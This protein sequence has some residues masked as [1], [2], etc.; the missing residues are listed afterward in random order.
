M[1]KVLA[2]TAIALIAVIAFAGTSSLFY[3]GPYAES[4]LQRMLRHRSGADQGY[5]IFSEKR[6][7]FLS[8]CK[9]KFFLRGVCSQSMCA[10]GDSEHH[11]KN[12]HSVYSGTVF[13]KF[14][15]GR[16]DV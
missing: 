3:S 9:L 7:C 2:V 5:V 13:F 1:K 4:R 11:S 15:K 16:D 6:A 12:V 10:G 14:K 8:F